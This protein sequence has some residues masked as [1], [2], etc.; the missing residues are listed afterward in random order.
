MKKI[1]LTEFRQLSEAS[2]SFN[3][4][5]KLTLK[6]IKFEYM[7]EYPK[8]KRVVGDIFPKESDFV[9]AMKNAKV[10]KVNKAFDR[11]IDYRSGTRSIEDLK[12]LVS[13]Y[14][15][16]RDVDRIVQGYETNAKMPMPIVVSWNNGK[17]LRVMGG[18]TRMDTAFIMGIEPQV[19]ILDLDSYIRD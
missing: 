7:V 5:R 13:T 15:Y 9:S 12:D 14:Q 18:N 8:L 6:E 3:N 16:P 19:L 4:W 10:Q 17:N 11:K 1:T 2:L